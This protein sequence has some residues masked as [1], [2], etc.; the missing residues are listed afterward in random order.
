MRILFSTRNFWYVRIFEPVLRLLAERGHDI[1]I[2]AERGERKELA[3]QWNLA[4]ATLASEHPNITFGWAPLR[5]ENE[6]IDLRLMIRLGIDHLRF[7]TPEYAN[8]PKLAERART[9]TPEFVVRL[10]D[11]PVFRTDAGR[12]L[13]GMALRAA[14]R[15]L[16]IDPDVAANI[17]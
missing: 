5:I 6:W 11:A 3:E 2:L 4:M 14:E 1:H 8:A 13:I 16:P 7:L 15:A 10:A 17:E 12:K 9:R